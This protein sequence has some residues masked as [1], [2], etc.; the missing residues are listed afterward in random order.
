[1]LN[2]CSI[3]WNHVIYFDILQGDLFTMYSC[4]VFFLRKKA[5]LQE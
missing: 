3:E 1:M 2:D 4:S 5:M